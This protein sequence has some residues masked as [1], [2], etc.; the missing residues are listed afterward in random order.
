[1][2]KHY[3]IILLIIISVLLLSCSKDDLGRFVIKKMKPDYDFTNDSLPKAPDYSNV[4]EWLFHQ[5]KGLEV[6]IFYIH[7]TT[8]FSPKNWN[9]S[10]DDTITINR[11]MKH[12]V[13]KQLTPFYNLGNIYAPKYRQ[14]NF[15]S[16]IDNTQNG[17]QSI[18][19]AYQ[20][21]LNSFNY[22]LDNLNKKRP[23]ILV[24]HSQ[25]SR[26]IIKLMKKIS[27]DKN[28]ESKL[29]AAYAIGWP[30]TEKYIADNPEIKICTDSSMTGCIISWNTEGKRILYSIVKEKS[31][32]VNPLSWTTDLQ[33][34]EKEKHKGAVF[35]YEN[36]TDTIYNYVSAQNN[37]K[38]ALII[39][40]PPNLKD[41]WMPLKYGNY[42]TNDFNIF[43]I[44][45]QENAKH[46]IST[47]FKNNTIEIE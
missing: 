39:S 16:F 11:T 14:A 10:L 44:N 33:K 5:D 3:K 4:N 38:G 21:V 28:L 18:D 46:R 1:M 22:Y 41:L 23:F 26:Y 8:Y 20:D 30:I 25:G 45:I 40:K 37:E 15:Y 42:H 7:P 36:R 9:Q 24:G 29:I 17:K 32:S 12:P 43:Y 31:I 47:Y 27:N 6:D 19:L 34:I 35:F 13:K 2:F